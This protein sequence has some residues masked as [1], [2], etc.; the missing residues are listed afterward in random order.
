MT[1]LEFLLGLHV[2][3]GGVINVVAVLIGH[4][5]LLQVVLSWTHKHHP[6]TQ[7]L[8]GKFKP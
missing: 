1:Y 8:T 3:N 7:S 2:F 4:Q 5:V 6:V